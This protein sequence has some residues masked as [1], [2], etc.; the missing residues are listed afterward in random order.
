[1]EVSEVMVSLRNVEANGPGLLI[2]W[3]LPVVHLMVCKLSMVGCFATSTKIM[4]SVFAMA[5][6]NTSKMAIRDGLVGLA[7]GTMAR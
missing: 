1:M 2:S 5:V 7:M 4:H 6:P 3:G